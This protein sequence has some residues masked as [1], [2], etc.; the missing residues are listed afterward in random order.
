[1][2][3]FSEVFFYAEMNGGLGFNRGGLGMPPGFTISVGGASRRS[4]GCSFVYSG[5]SSAAARA[6][7]SSGSGSG[8]RYY[9]EEESSDDDFDEDD[10]E[11]VS[12]LWM[13]TETLIIRS[14]V[15]CFFSVLVCF[16]V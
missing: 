6:V 5:G 1:M 3:L 12:M 8:R 10:E 9:E 4:P 14:F 11:C 16:E 2:N 13:M 15:V 7:Y